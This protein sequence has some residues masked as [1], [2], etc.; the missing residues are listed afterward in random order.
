MNKSF[1]PAMSRALFDSDLVIT[2]LLLGF[3][4]LLWAVLLAWPGVTF[5][6]PTYHF[7]SH[8]MAEEM[9]AVVF[10][11]SGITQIFIVGAEQ[12]HGLFARYFAGWNAALWCFVVSSMLMSVYPPPAAIS[13]EIM[14]AIAAFWIWIRPHIILKGIEHA[15]ASR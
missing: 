2:R 14:L 8:V 15:R 3:S 5:E 6:R 1:V 10:L 11:F 13:G 4:E 12:F 9:W 7:M